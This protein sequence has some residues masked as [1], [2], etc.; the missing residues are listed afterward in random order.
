M[1]DQRLLSKAVASSK[2][3][4]DGDAIARL[5]YACVVFGDNQTK[6]EPTQHNN[7]NL[8]TE[9]GIL[10]WHASSRTWPFLRVGFSSLRDRSHSDPEVRP[11][12]S[13][14]VHRL[15]GLGLLSA[16]SDRGVGAQ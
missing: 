2:R 9:F 16:Q 10:S 3:G 14:T 15:E 5:I 11:L 12:V 4:V 7:N 6:S 1:A 8:L 13:A